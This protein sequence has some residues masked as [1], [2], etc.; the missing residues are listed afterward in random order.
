MFDEIL[1]DMLSDP[2]LGADIEV[3]YHIISGSGIGY[4]MDPELKSLVHVSRGTEI[5][6][7]E[8]VNSSYTLVRG[9]FNYLIVPNDEI[10]ELG[11]N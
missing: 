10:I 11:Y 2:E 8:E 3:P 9:Q 7:I 6:P 5:V 4:F 1:K